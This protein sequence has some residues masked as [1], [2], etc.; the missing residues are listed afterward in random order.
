MSVENLSKGPS[1]LQYMAQHIMLIPVVFSSLICHLCTHMHA[2]QA[3]VHKLSHMLRDA[4]I[5]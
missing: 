1:T 4:S 2:T 5:N 3:Y